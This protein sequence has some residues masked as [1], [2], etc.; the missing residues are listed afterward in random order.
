MISNHSGIFSDLSDVKT[1]AEHKIRYMKELKQ[2]RQKFLEQK[3]FPS[4][5]YHQDKKKLHAVCVYQHVMRLIFIRGKHLHESLYQAIQEPNAYSGLVLLKAYWETAGIMGYGH[6]S[7]R[8]MIKKNNMMNLLI[9]LLEIHLE[10][11]AIHRMNYL[12]RRG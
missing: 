3:Q 5:E 12:R 4:L 6:I 7:G 1:D 11:K 8:K 9:G 10:E 2:I